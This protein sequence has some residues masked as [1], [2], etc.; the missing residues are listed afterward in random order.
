M[1]KNF[2]AS[3]WRSFSRQREYRFQ[4]GARFVEPTGSD[5]KLDL[6]ERDFDFVGVVVLFTECD[7]GFTVGLF[8][9]R[10]ITELGVGETD[11]VQHLRFLVAQ[12]QRLIAFAAQDECLESSMG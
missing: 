11:V 5:A 12:S 4:S 9:A 10:D 3:P 2:A 8:R 1:P 7:C 6:V